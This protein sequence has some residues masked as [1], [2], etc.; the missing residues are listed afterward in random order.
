MIPVKV[1]L[2]ACASAFLLAGP[3]LA[4]DQTQSPAKDKRAD[5]SVHEIMQ[6][7]NRMLSE[8][9]SLAALE[10]YHRAEKL[11][12]DAPEIAFGRGLAHYRLKEMEEAREAF[13]KAATAS[14]PSL[15]QDA[16]YSMATCDH[17]EALQSS[18]DPQGAVTKLESAMQ[19]YHDVLSAN[20]RHEAAIDANLKAAASWRQLKQLLQQQQQQQQ[21]D[22]DQK[23]KDQQEKQDQQQ[24]DKQKQ[25]QKKQEGDKQEQSEKEQQESSQ[26]QK[27]PK[28]SQQ[29]EGKEDQE[30]KQSSAKEEQKEQKPSEAQEQQRAEDK[31]KSSNEQA[32][33]R[34]REMV[35]AMQQ[36]KRNRAQQV[37]PIAPPPT[38]KDW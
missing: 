13:R 8:G 1:I 22:G 10:A 18:A 31:E 33:R 32:Q 38:E 11:L 29:E 4:Q 16:K 30:K 7:A 23:D 21:Q 20:P 26:E 3:S 9:Q 24:Q 36:R 19:Q 2:F 37:Q 35:Q 25:D 12:P 5:P 34:L 14:D 27:D 28:S 17:A 15:S 6:D